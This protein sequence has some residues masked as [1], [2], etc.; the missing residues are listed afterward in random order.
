MQNM[1]A[2]GITTKAAKKDVATRTVTYT[3]STGSVHEYVHVLDSS[4]TGVSE[5]TALLDSTFLV[6]ERDGDFPSATGYKKLWKADFRS[7][8]DV[9]SRSKVPG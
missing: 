1:L 5:I 6:D 8:T 2:N 3:L 9:G 7:A 4:G